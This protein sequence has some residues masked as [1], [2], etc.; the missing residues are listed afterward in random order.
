MKNVIGLPARGTSFY[1]RNREIEKV[2]RALANG[3]NIQIT[4][5]RRVG[6]TSI[7]WYLL[8]NNIDDRHYIY[9]LTLKV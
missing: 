7:L 8:D 1:Q 9:I 3:N 5:P 2:T 6:K 4:A